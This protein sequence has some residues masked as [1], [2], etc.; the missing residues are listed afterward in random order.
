[1]RHWR[2]YAALGA[3]VALGSGC[4]DWDNPAALADL[5][6]Q[7]EFEVEADP[8]ETYDEIEIHVHVNDGTV[9]LELSSGELEIQHIDGGAVRAL[10]LHAEGDGYAAHP[11]FFEP[12]EHHVHL[13][14]VVSGHHLMTEMGE[15]EV[16]ALRHHAVIGPYWVEIEMSPGQVLPDEEGHIHLYAFTMTGDGSPDQPA[17]GLNMQVE[18]HDTVG[19]ETLLV[20]VEEAAGEYELQYVFGDAGTYEL[21]VEIDVGGVGMTGEFQ[22]PVLAPDQPDDSQTTGD[23]HGHTH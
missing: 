16:E 6:L 1:M 13:H 10:E 14:G 15:T 9:P 22:L 3:A 18:V 8:V 7:V 21:H 5:N 4:A 17:A 19:E 12:G 11:I 23:G 20:P 2:S